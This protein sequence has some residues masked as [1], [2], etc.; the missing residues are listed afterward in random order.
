MKEVDLRPQRFQVIGIDHRGSKRVPFGFV[1]F[2]DDTRVVF[3]TKEG[4]RGTLAPS[5][6]GDVTQEHFN[7]AMKALKRDNV[8]GFE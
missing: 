6:W 7:L 4:E 1:M 3:S 2:S 8:K 5:N